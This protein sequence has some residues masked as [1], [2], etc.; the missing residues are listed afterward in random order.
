M[1]GSTLNARFAP[2]RRAIILDIGSR[3]EFGIASDAGLIKQ[4]MS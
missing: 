4:E 2:A 1:T 3:K